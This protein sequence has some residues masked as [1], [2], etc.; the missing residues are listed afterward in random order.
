MRCV[1]KSNFVGK[2]CT[3]CAR[4]FYP[5][6]TS[7]KPCACQGNEDKEADKYCNANSYGWCVYVIQS[8]SLTDVAF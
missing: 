5:D 2:H 1:C 6:V 4:G 7:C 3:E 8:V